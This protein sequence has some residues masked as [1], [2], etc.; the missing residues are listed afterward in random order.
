VLEARD[1]W[2]W[3]SG[4]RDKIGVKDEFQ[5][6]A[7]TLAG[8]READRVSG[9]L[10]SGAR[11]REGA[12]TAMLAVGREIQRAL[13]LRPL[14]VELNR[15]RPCFTQRLRLD[16]ER[17][18][19]AMITRAAALKDCVQ[20]DST[21]VAFLPAGGDWPGASASTIAC[22]ILQESEGRFDL[23]LFDMPPMLE[24]A[25][26]LAAGSVVKDLIIVV[27]AGRTSSEVLSLI[28][29]QSEGAGMRIAGSILTMQQRI[30]PRWLDRW[31]V[32]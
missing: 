6:V 4:A 32:G 10:F 3:D 15:I 18:V 14:L 1:N 30:V 29:Q 5:R 7:L 24:S 17:S 25:D 12:S 16:S 26:T 8:S 23:V 20:T 21:G 11:P 28:R 27:R 19:H 22:R 13:R 2:P 31:L 9:V